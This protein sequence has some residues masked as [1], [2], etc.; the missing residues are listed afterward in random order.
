MLDEEGATSFFAGWESTTLGYFIAGGIAFYATEYFRR[1][2][3]SLVKSAAMALSG[4]AASEISAQAFQSN[5]EIPL[6]IASAA[7]S[8]FICCFFIAPFD[9]VRIR[10]VSQP[11]Y[12]PNFFAVCSRMIKE[13]GLA[14]LFSAVPVWFLKEIP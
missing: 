8:A 6:I 7:T 4:P 1:Y 5:L 12:A 14:S 11:D 9:A 10:T 3:G 2:Y 13:E